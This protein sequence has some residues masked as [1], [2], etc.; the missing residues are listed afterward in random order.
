MTET[1]PME[2]EIT[3]EFD[4]PGALVF[5]NW[6]EAEH[7]GA[8]FAPA[9]FDVVECAVDLRPGGHWRVAYHSAQG[10]RY[11]EYGQFI[12]VVRPELLHLTLINENGRG[13]VMLRTEVKVTFRE[14]NGKTMMTFVQTGLPSA[15]LR[16]SVHGGWGTCFDKLDR[17][18]AADR[19][20]RELFA[21]WFRASE[22]KD[23]DAAMRPI[24]DDVLSYEHESPLAYHGVEALRAICKTGFEHMPGDLRWDVPDLHVVVR[25]DI[26]VTWG[27][28]HMNG[29]GVDMW[30]RGTRIF[31]KIDGR[32]Q[33]VHQHVSFPYDPATGAARLDLRP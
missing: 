32:W 11:T 2:I 13:E 22:R 14:Q 20:L 30:S 9:G 21:D 1:T 33:M 31:Q 29:S 16:H 24:A 15:D 17:Q 4:A 26:A 5:A 25:G 27:L 10:D 28:N 23:L 18:L 6:T 7:L 3:R 12:E 8:W 19:E